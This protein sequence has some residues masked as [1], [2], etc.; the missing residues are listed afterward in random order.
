MYFFKYTTPPRA[1]KR[2]L[3]YINFCY[4]GRS[5]IESHKV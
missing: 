2:F 3:Q 5:Y 4:S 1:V